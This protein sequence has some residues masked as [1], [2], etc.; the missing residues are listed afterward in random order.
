MSLN[1]FAARLFVVKEVW[2]AM[3]TWFDFVIDCD[4]NQH[5]VLGGAFSGHDENGWWFT[6]SHFLEK[7]SFG[8]KVHFPQDDLFNWVVAYGSRWCNFGCD[9]CKDCLGLDVVYLPAVA[10]KAPDPLSNNET[11]FENWTDEPKLARGLSFR[12]P[13]MTWVWVP[14]WAALCPVLPRKLSPRN[15]SKLS[16]TVLHHYGVLYAWCWGTFWWVSR[17]VFNL[18]SYATSRFRLA[19]CTPLVPCTSLLWPC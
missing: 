5:W 19:Q 16:R 8:R 15:G 18:E 2:F 17:A 1:P 9:Y 11:S 4:V 3:F 10:S 6:N 7:I 14:L 12:I 13:N